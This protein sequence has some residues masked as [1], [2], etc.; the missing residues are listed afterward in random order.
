MVLS[1][2]HPCMCI[3]LL[4]L[5]S[6][7]QAVGS[8]YNQAMNQKSDVG[9]LFFIYLF[10]YTELSSLDHVILHSLKF[11]S[12]FL[13][14]HKKYLMRESCRRMNHHGGLTVLQRSYT[15]NNEF[16]KATSHIL[17]VYNMCVCLHTHNICIL[18]HM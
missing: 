5:L 15:H 18:T 14:A 16:Q 4:R 10:H 9:F 7:E 6:W 2:L 3:W 8:E 11:V 17:S 13:D 1:L 12:I